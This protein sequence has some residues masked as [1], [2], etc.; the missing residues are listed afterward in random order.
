M[1]LAFGLLGGF[2]GAQAPEFAQ[3]YRQRLG[4]RVD[5][6][7]R[8]VNGFEQEAKKNNKTIPQAL[9]ILEEAQ[10][11]IVR[12]RGV[13]MRN[14]M[15]RLRIS[16]QQLREMNEA[17]PFARIV[18]LLHGI[19][20]PTASSTLSAFE[21]AIPVTSEG[22]ATTGIGFGLFYWLIWFFQRMV[23]RLFG[24]S[25]RSNSGPKPSYAN[26]QQRKDRLRAATSGGKFGQM[27]PDAQSPASPPGGIAPGS[28][29]LRK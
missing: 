6:L 2:M 11:P 16:T 8:S 28:S 10:D 14:D 18:L 9:T 25:G 24:F 4:G 20:A 23:S 3:Q 13:T 29:L 17:G 1:A 7:Q 27:R 26:A 21:P 19:D 5:E 12:H 22:L 15:E